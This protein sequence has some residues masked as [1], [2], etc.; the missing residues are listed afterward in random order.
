MEAREAV[1]DAYDRLERRLAEL[2]PDTL[3]LPA[4]AWDRLLRRSRD[5]G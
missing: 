2:P 5:G 4:D 3:P 1:A